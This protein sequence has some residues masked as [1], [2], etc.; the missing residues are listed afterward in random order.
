MKETKGKKHRYFV[1]VTDSFCEK[2]LS[3]NVI[4][5]IGLNIQHVLFS[6]RGVFNGNNK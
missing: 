6:F 5:F 1:K 4:Q 2:S 3:R